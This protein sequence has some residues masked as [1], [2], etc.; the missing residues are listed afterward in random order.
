MWRITDRSNSNSVHY[1]A[2]L[3]YDENLSII[4]SHCTLPRLTSKEKEYYYNDFDPRNTINRQTGFYQVELDKVEPLSEKINNKIRKMNGHT[5]ETDS[6]LEND[7]GIEGASELFDEENEDNSIEN[8]DAESIQDNTKLS[9]KSQ[10][11]DI[12]SEQDDNISDDKSQ[13]DENAQE[14]DENKSQTT[15]EDETQN[16]DSS[17]SN[18]LWNGKSFRKR[19]INKRIYNDE[20]YIPS[21]R[22]QLLPKSKLNQNKEKSVTFDDDAFSV[23]D[24]DGNL[25]IDDEID[26]DFENLQRYKYIFCSSLLLL[27]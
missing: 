24:K 9:D 12:A 25:K 19:P 22:R 5:V 16:E 21:K 14:Q 15:N 13:N 1:R 10:N 3:D 20:N 6:F 2:K 18:I 23:F 7:V 27:L 17:S 11:E 26:L 4:G 8:I